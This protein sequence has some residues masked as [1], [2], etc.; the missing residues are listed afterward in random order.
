MVTIVSR[1]KSSTT[2]EN[3]ANLDDLSTE[4]RSQRIRDGLCPCCGTQLF[5]TVRKGLL[6]KKSTRP[7]SVAGQCIRGHCVPCMNIDNDEDNSAI[8][9]LAATVEPSTEANLLVP[10]ATTA[11]VQAHNRMDNSYSGNFNNYG[12]RHGEGML[13]WKNG[14]KYTGSF[15]NGL[16]EGEGTLTFSD[17]SE[18]VGSWKDNKMHGKGTRRFPNGNVYTG[19]YQEGKRSGDGRCYYANGDMYTGEWGNDQMNGFG[20]YYYSNGQCFEGFFFGR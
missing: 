7:L 3:T 6:R 11:P 2:P 14:D 17:G 8:I 12:E 4:L 10:T 5:E 9:A 20:R 13:T 15:W 1:R 16:P 18:Y 19:S